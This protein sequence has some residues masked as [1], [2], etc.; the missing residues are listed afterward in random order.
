[1]SRAFVKEQDDA[2]EELSE[3]PVSANPNFVTPRG[4]GLIDVEILALRQE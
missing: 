1:M 3:R 2:P 4:L